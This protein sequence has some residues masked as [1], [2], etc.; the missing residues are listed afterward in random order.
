VGA[1]PALRQAV[2]RF[3]AVHMRPMEGL[4]GA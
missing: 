2:A 1:S 4:A 3:A